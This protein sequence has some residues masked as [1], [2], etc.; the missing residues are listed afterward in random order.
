MTTN[1]NGTGRS[2]VVGPSAVRRD[3]ASMPDLSGLP[4]GFTWG[5]A[6]AAF[7]IEGDAEH[8]GDSIWDEFCR[9]PGRI[10]DRSDGRVACDHVNRYRQDVGLLE[11]LGVDAYRFSVSWPRVV[12]GGRGPVS[13][14]GLDFYD[15]L[16]DA[17]MEAG[18][19]P[20]IT[21]YHWDLPISLQAE[22]GWASRS[23][24]DPFVEYA[25]AVHSALGD[26]VRYWTTLNEPWC[27][28]WL[29]YGNG[30][31]APGVRD[32][33]AGARAA[34]HLLLAH[35]SATR[36]MRSQAPADHQFGVVH[37]IAP[38]YAVPGAPEAVAEAAYV[39]DG[40]RN[41]WWL[42][43]MFTAAYPRDTLELLAPALDGFILDGDLTE[44]A[45]PIDFMGVNY[46]SDL[47]F[48]GL[49]E[50][51]PHAEPHP[52]PI[53]VTVVPPG[54]DETTMGWDV[55][56][57]GLREIL[58]RVGKAYPQ[59]PWLVVTE[60]GS[61]YLD[62]FE[63]VAADGYLEDPR[64]EAYLLRHLEALAAA[65]REG[66]DVRGYFVWS[67][68]DN[69]EWA[70]GYTQ[71]FGLVS[72]DFQSQQRRPKRSFDTYR[73]VIAYQRR[74]AVQGTPATV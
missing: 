5:T 47:V 26:R 63:A 29:G 46:Y 6:T 61:A 10:L 66:A 15:R 49:G 65:V 56:P 59:A 3:D 60:N 39:V 55:T 34:H 71:R 42:D 58:V 54:P 45:A 67:M 24:V 2:G 40:F 25:L 11:D 57:D 53:A 64:R 22:G 21:L 48:D 4:V 16:V 8:R 27:S 18:I 74:L 37:N 35:G 68:L 36:A 28:A 44:I 9:E 32:H 70:L 41:R 33:T 13:G 20:W 7:Q 38:A 31:H 50:S 12:P 72:V 62:D 23:V 30:Q 14:Q 19:H 43:S 52:M 17:L 51:R 1:S 73:Q 69:F